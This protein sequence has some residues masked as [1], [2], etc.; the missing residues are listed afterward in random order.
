ML[1]LVGTGIFHLVEVSEVPETGTIHN[2]GSKLLNAG[3]YE[4]NRDGD[5][6]AYPYFWKTRC[7]DV[8]EGESVLPC[9]PMNI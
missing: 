5:R 9:Y 2:L 3:R 1:I 7:G 6:D 8:L 4:L